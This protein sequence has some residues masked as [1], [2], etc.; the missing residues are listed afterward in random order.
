MAD[1]EPT[2]IDAAIDEVER[3]AMEEEL[4]KL[5]RRQAVRIPLL[6]ER[7]TW[8]GDQEITIGAVP[9]DVPTLLL[10]DDQ[11]GAFRAVILPAPVVRAYSL[12]PLGRALRRFTTG[13]EIS[14]GFGFSG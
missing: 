12:R 10:W 11:Q 1:H 13:R 6:V 3:K 9:G 4:A 8:T 2:P 7:H 5:D 14:I